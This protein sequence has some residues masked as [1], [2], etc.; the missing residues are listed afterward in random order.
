MPYNDP[1]TGMHLP[2]TSV[3]FEILLAL[4]DEPRHGY[5]VM[6]EVE[7]RSGT[8]LRAGTLY[9]AINRMLED[10]YIEE[11]TD[12]DR[13]E[14]D[15]ERRRYYRLTDF[16]FRVLQAET[17]RLAKLVAIARERN[18]LGA[19]GLTGSSKA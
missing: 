11:M 8:R 2:L 19:P 6:Q 15:D 9:R 1:D 3:V 4:A 12:R 17:N 14:N 13:P 18:V 16:G 7:R 10:G 5:A